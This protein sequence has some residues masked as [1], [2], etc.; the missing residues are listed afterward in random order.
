VDPYNPVTQ[1][2]KNDENIGWTIPELTKALNKD[3]TDILLTRW[4]PT[5]L[6]LIVC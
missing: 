6:Q 3:P 4:P 2:G 5:P 1:A